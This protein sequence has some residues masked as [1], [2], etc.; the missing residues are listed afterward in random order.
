MLAYPRKRAAAGPIVLTL[1][2]LGVVAAAV[3]TVAGEAWSADPLPAAPPHAV[4]IAAEDLE[5][6]ARGVG[7]LG[8]KLQDLDGPVAKALELPAG[9][10]ALISGV[11]SKSPAAEGGLQEGDVVVRFE[12]KSIKNSR[13]LTKLVQRA[14]PG[15]EVAIVV[16][17]AGK[18]K[19]VTVKLGE[20]ERI[21][22]PRWV[23]PDKDSPAAPMPRG[24]DDH[25]LQVLRFGDEAR[26]YLGVELDDLGEQLGAYFG[27]EDGKGA[28]VREVVADSP[29]EKAGLRA[30]DVITAM[31]GMQT[32]DAGD[33]RKTLR[34]AD[35][36]DR[37]KITVMRDRRS[38]EI[39]ATLG[40]PPASDR[41]RLGKAERLLDNMRLRGRA[42][43]PRARDHIEV[44]RRNLQDFDDQE[45][46]QLREDLE[47]LRQELQELR[48]KIADKR[49]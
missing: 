39:E 43:E 16:R 46:Q 11:E 25:A 17:R 22:E 41:L 2:S 48:D 9:E 19:Q 12:G 35:A 1:L 32:D 14:D 49:R 29:A 30:G 18:E 27:V 36:G 6:N 3:P 24:D 21:K 44:L 37:V 42:L 15:Q 38:Q 33:V 13:D 4:V 45:L 8:V 7:W 34:N 20:R 31:D 10:G 40:E 5:D 26:A 28:L 47:K 23:V